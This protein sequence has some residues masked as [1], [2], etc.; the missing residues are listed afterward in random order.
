MSAREAL[1]IATRGG[2]ACLGRDDIGVLEPGRR[3]DVAL[4]RLDGL[5][6]VGAETDPVA[7]LLFCQ[8]GRVAHLIVEGRPVVQDGVL[9][10]MDERRVIE[11]GRRAARQ[12]RD[13]GGPA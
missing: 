13:V 5:G 4:F 1:R 7:A 8:P 12:I 6:M 10:T 3:G 9:V 2:A 11:N